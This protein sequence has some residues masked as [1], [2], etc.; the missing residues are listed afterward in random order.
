M[1]GVTG[2]FGRFD[3]AAVSSGVDRAPSLYLT[4]IGSLLAFTG[5]GWLLRVAPLPLVATYA[6]V[7]PVVAVILGAASSTSRSTPRTLVAG[8][9]HR[10]RGRA[11]RDRARPDAAPARRDGR[12]R[13]ARDRPA[14]RAGPGHHGQHRVD[15]DGVGNSDRSATYSPSRYATVDG[16]LRRARS[17]RTRDAR[18]AWPP[19]RTVPIWWAE[20]TEPRFG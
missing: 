2:E 6:Y 3:P 9:G 16:P 11:H 7:N 19:I 18:A 17:D 15:P 12:S 13:S 20:K 4:V 1:A 5:F 10:R 14:P 8:G